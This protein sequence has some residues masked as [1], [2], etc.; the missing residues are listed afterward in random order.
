MKATAAVLIA[1]I[2]V[3][4]IAGCGPSR[5]ERA[6]NEAF[7]LS[8]E[9]EVCL[10]FGDLDAAERA[11][12]EALAVKDATETGGA[13]VVLGDI[14]L[15]RRQKDTDEFRR[16]AAELLGRAAVMTEA[17]HAREAL[18]LLA[19]ALPQTSATEQQ[20]AQ[21][22]WARV[23]TVTSDQGAA[24][25][26]A[27]F[28]L[29]ALTDFREKGRLPEHAASTVADGPPHGDALRRLWLA[30]LRRTLPVALAEAEAKADEVADPDHSLP[31]PTLEQVA[32]DPKSW[33]G[34][35]V[36]FDHVWLSGEMF[37]SMSHGRLLTVTSSAGKTYEPYV[38]S[39]ALVF[40][41]YSD[42]ARKLETVLGPGR[43]SQARLFC[44]IVRGHES[45]PVQATSFYLA[46]VFKVEVYAEEDQRH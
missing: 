32:A 25:Y 43:K 18:A 22:L 41:T 1:W 44:K 35:Q 45:G 16:R 10:K 2:G 20:L 23:L 8:S 13:D 12:K 9:A 17:G 34:K 37:T 7:R 31:A 46:M 36:Q 3:I 6:N 39:G 26:W 5:A 11:A 29:A 24:R 33:V 4:G 28:D 15:A 19:K 38:R 40:S 27:A 14:R 42:V 30:T 21:T